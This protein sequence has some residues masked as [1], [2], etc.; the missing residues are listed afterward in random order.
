MM[1]FVAASL[2]T[3]IVGIWRESMLAKVASMV[4]AYGLQVDAF[5]LHLGHGG[6]RE[7]VV[8]DVLYREIDNLVDEAD[9]AVLAGGNACHDLT[10]GNLGI[11]DGFASP[12]AIVDHHHE[13][14]H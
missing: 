9:V 1:E 6:L 5:R 10:P 11:D 4:G 14:L 13:I 12:P 7:D 8:G 2:R 3:L